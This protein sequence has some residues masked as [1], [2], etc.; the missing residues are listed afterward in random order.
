MKM[1]YLN[2]KNGQHVWHYYETD[3]AGPTKELHRKHKC[4]QCK[5]R[6]RFVNLVNAFADDNIWKR[7]LHD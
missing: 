2:A 5:A 4:F 3:T 7:R 6:Q 1:Y